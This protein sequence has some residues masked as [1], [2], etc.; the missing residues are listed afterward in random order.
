MKINVCG[1]EKACKS[2][3]KQCSTIWENEL[4]KI[5]VDRGVWLTIQPGNERCIVLQFLNNPLYEFPFSTLMIGKS[6]TCTLHFYIENVTVPITYQYDISGYLSNYDDYWTR[7]MGLQS[8]SAHGSAYKKDSTH[9][10]SQEHKKAYFGKHRNGILLFKHNKH[11]TNIPIKA[12]LQE[13]MPPRENSIKFLIT[14][15]KWISWVDFY[16]KKTDIPASYSERLRLSSTIQIVDRIFTDK[17]L[18]ITINSEDMDKNGTEL[19][20]T[21]ETQ[22]SIAHMLLSALKDSRGKYNSGNPIWLPV[23]L[24]LYD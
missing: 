17:I 19:T 3:L 18:K 2:S 14:L 7:I 21:I 16:I 13:K 24:H 10:I 12:S 1:V 6:F 15:I 23:P 11:V 5:R 20:V 4:V 22:V 8:F 9:S